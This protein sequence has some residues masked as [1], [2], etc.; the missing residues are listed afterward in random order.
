MFLDANHQALDGERGTACLLGHSSAVFFLRSD[1]FLCDGL[2][3]G[4]NWVYKIE[5]ATLNVVGSFL[6]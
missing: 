4:V 5:R 3:L 1:N 6:H 2:H